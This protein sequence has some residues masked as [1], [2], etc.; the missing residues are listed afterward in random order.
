MTWL[1]KIFCCFFFLHV[2]SA[3][4]SQSENMTF[5]YNWK[6]TNLPVRAGLN[7]SYND[8]WGYEADDRYYVIIGSL[9]YAHFFDVT[10]PTNPVE[11][12][13]IGGINMRNN[14]LNNSIWRDFDTFE[15]YAYMVA[16]EGSEGLTVFDLSALPDTVYK[17]RQDTNHLIKAHTLYIDKQN[18]RLYISGVGNNIIIYGLSNPAEPNHLATIDLRPIA[19]LNNTYIHDVFARDNIV[20]ASHGYSGYCAYNMNNVN[21][22]IKLSCVN[23]TFGYNHSSWAT[24]DNQFLIY[25]EE[26]PRGKPLVVLHRDS[27]VN[28]MTN[29]WKTFKEPLLAPNH[30]DVTPHNPYIQGDLVYV[31]YYEDGVVVFDISDPYNPSRIAYYDTY[32]SNNNYN[33]TR[34]CWA[35]YPFFSNGLIAASDTENG[36]FLMELDIQPLSVDFIRFDVDCPAGKPSISW[37]TAQTRK[38]IVFTLQGSYDARHFEDIISFSPEEKLEGSKRIPDSNPYFYYRLRSEDVLGRTTY[39]KIRSSCLNDYKLKVFPNPASSHM[40]SINLIYP[41]QTDALSVRLIDVHGKEIIILEKWYGGND[42]VNISG[43]AAGLY[44]VKMTDSSGR[45][46][47]GHKILLVD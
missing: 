21:N 18:A 12:S 43:L 19:G 42:Q 23:L 1:L 20:Y 29:Y 13:R 8:L 33:G 26:L 31:S 28:D 17:I 15:T 22:P 5:F 10:D 9:S 35:V 46:V 44:W 47:S 36:L 4:I 37:K 39:S 41:F 34:G 14:N 16:D 45:M 40:G 24:D 27:F 30:M 25:A 6:D 7:L 11:V 2:I 38:D 32:P 3:G